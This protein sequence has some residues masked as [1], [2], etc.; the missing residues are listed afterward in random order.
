MSGWHVVKRTY[1]E[2]V[3]AAARVE[4]AVAVGSSTVDQLVVESAEAAEAHEQARANAKTEFP[5]PT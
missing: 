3:R 5:W 4:A 1:A 2:R